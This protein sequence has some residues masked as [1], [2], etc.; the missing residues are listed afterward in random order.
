MPSGR[1]SNSPALTP[2]RTSRPSELV[3]IGTKTENES[4]AG[5]IRVSP[6]APDSLRAPAATRRVS[7]AGWPDIWIFLVA[8]AKP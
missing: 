4:C 5:A 6:M 8:L 1:R 7:V 2:L 3:P